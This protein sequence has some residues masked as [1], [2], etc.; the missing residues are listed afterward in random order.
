MLGEPTQDQQAFLESVDRFMARHLPPDE[1]RRRDREHEPPYHLLPLMG[2]A[3]LLGVPFPECFGGLDRPFSD[4]VFIQ[5]RLA[6]HGLMAASLFARTV[7][8]GGMTLLLTSIPFVNFLAMPAAVAG[9]TLLWLEQFS[10]EP[11]APNTE[12][13]PFATS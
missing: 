9:A 5:E 12:E 13:K 6:R 1:V 11:P 3:G 4:A 2:E 10:Q 7:S 8:F